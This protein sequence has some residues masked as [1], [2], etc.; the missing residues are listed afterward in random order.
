MQTASVPA[1]SFHLIE[2]LGLHGCQHRQSLPE[3]SFG[4]IRELCLNAPALKCLLKLIQMARERTQI[5]S[6]HFLSQHERHRGL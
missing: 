6:L 5:D 1:P 2:Q 3:G 4:V